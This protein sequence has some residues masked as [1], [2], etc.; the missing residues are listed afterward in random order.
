LSN[1]IKEVSL[2]TSNIF[3]EALLKCLE[4]DVKSDS[5]IGKVSNA[6]LL[7]GF[8]DKEKYVPQII[9]VF[10]VS[11]KKVGYP[12]LHNILATIGDHRATKPLLHYVFHSHYQIDAACAHTPDQ[13]QRN[14]E[15]VISSLEKL[16]GRFINNRNETILDLKTGLTWTGEPVN[17]QIIRKE[18][19]MLVHSLDIVGYKHWRLPTKEELINLFNSFKDEDDSNYSKKA[20]WFEEKG[21]SE[22]ITWD[23][24]YHTS[25]SGSLYDWY[26]HVG[27]EGTAIEDPNEFIGCLL[28][29]TEEG[30]EWLNFKYMGPKKR[31]IGR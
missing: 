5:D 21:F 27:V 14:I 8:I 24:F 20:K 10:E 30:A 3:F 26:Y 9:E 19:A 2:E 1:N 18:A 4:R 15:G 31:E 6:S 11:T 29:V 7:L 23:S 16:G 22:L 13:I 12:F 17:R 28:P 25:S